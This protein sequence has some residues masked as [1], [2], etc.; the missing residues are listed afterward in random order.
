MVVVD[1]GIAEAGERYRVVV[2]LLRQMASVDGNS[3][4]H[5]CV[6][7]LTAETEHRLRMGGGPGVR[8]R[9]RRQKILQDVPAASAVELSR[10][11]RDSLAQHELRRR[12]YGGEDPSEFEVTVREPRPTRPKPRPPVTRVPKRV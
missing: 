6:D 1:V 11:P 4:A 7:I 2:D 10:H 9:M 3:A 5:E 12:C 8:C